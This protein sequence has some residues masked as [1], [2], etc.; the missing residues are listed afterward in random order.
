MIDVSLISLGMIELHV[1]PTWLAQV[2]DA[3]ERSLQQTL[4]DR[5]LEIQID[6]AAVPEEPI[7]ADTERILQVMRKIVT[8]AIKYTP[9]GGRIQV[10]A[11]SLPGFVDLMVTD[12]GIGIAAEQLPHIFS[13]FAFTGDASLHSSSKTKFRGGGPGLGLF[14]SK[15]LVEA[16]GGNI[17]AESPGYD[18][19][20]CPGST[21]HVLIPLRTSPPVNALIIQ[22]EE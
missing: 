2:L 10:T 18:E 8:N 15:G 4:Q 14:I 20:A 22:Q 17:W 3:L 16:H 7:Y 1:Q 19:D 21:F 11:R 9:D 13:M 12:S 6:Y 5:D